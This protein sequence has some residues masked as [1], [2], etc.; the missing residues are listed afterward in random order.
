MERRKLAD[1]NEWLQL[2]RETKQW[3]LEEPEIF[4]GDALPPR[5]DLCRAIDAVF[6]GFLEDQRLL[7]NQTDKRFR[8]PL[9][10]NQPSA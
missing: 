6:A 10:I 5:R 8:I 2:V 3:I 9:W 4:F 7:A 1:V